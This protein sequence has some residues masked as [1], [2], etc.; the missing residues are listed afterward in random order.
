MIGSHDIGIS[1]K[2]VLV[3]FDLVHLIGL[4]LCGTIVMDDS[5]SSTQLQQ[6]EK[7]VSLFH[8]NCAAIQKRLT[9]S[10]IAISDSVT[11]SMGDETSGALRVISLVSGDDNSTSSEMKS[12]KPG[13]IIKSLKRRK[14]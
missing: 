7:K 14:T 6:E 12:M 4:V 2:T 9:A 10:A 11:V 5:N 1:N 3:L 8:I 13:N